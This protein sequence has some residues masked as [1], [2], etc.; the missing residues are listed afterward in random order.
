MKLMKTVRKM[1]K[2]YWA[3]GAVVVVLIVAIL[4]IM[5][6]PRQ[7]D[8]TALVARSFEEAVRIAPDLQ[9]A[10]GVRLNRDKN[11]GRNILLGFVGCWGAVLQDGS[12][13]LGESDQ[14]EIVYDADGLPYDLT[15]VP[16]RADL[17]LILHPDVPESWR[18]G[19]ITLIP[20]Q[21][22]DPSWFYVAVGIN[23]ADNNYDASLWYWSPGAQEYLPAAGEPESSA[24]ITGQRI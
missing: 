23:T 15:Q 12:V 18:G 14:K 21:E 5:L 3:L 4:A 7:E 17:Y 10:T 1:Q 16:I 20:N 13:M 19:V 11:H 9:N 22:G 24:G 2:L 6:W 8:G